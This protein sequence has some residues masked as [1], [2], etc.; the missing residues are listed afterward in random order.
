MTAFAMDH[1]FLA[2][3]EALKRPFVVGPPRRIPC[4]QKGSDPWNRGR[5][6]LSEAK[7][8]SGC[9]NLIRWRWDPNEELKCVIEEEPGKSLIKDH[10]EKLCNGSQLLPPLD[11]S[12]VMS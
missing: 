3:I 7:V 6:F 12:G 11:W 9:D 4:W 8:H 1:S 10:N 2:N 5:G